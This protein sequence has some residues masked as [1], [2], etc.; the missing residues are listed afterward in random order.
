[1]VVAA[2]LAPLG[3]II[4]QAGWGNLWSLVD[5]SFV[6]TLLWN[7]VRLAVVV[8][9]LSAIIGT[10][11]AWLTDRTAL[12]GRR[13]WAVLLIAPIVIPDFVLAWTWSSI[14]PAVHGGVEIAEAV[15]H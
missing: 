11:A 5:R 13:I 7:T 10:G 14:F 4:V 9:V 1:M 2:L 15:P 8:T 6:G 3:L 12:P